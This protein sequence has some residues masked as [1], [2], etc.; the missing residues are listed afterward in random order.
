[1]RRVI[2]FEFQGDGYYFPALARRGPL[3]SSCCHGP[4]D[5]PSCDSP[6]LP[7]VRPPG[8]LCAMV[9][10]PWRSA[11]SCRAPLAARSASGVS[12]PWRSTSPDE[13]SARSRHL[14][15]RKDHFCMALA[16]GP[17]IR[18]RTFSISDTKYTVTAIRNGAGKWSASSNCPISGCDSA[19]LNSLASNM[20]SPELAFSICIARI[21]QHFRN[22]H[23]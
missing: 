9:V 3:Q 4:G 8:V 10:T 16:T 18:R 15:V 19:G 13:Q 20:P 6:R 22:S 12:S 17:R 21:G 14:P 11:E 2:V 5:L 1:M 7:I 23:A